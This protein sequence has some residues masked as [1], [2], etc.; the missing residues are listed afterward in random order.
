MTTK[1]DNCF[2]GGVQVQY[3][4][5]IKSP[6]VIVGESP[7]VMEVSEGKPFVG[8]SGQ[9]LE[10]A[11]APYMSLFVTPP[12]ITNAFGCMPRQKDPNKVT[13][14]TMRCNARLLG[15]LKAHPRKVILALGN[16]ALWS[17]TGDYNKKITQVRGQVFASALASDGIVS[18]VHPAFLLRGG[19]NIQQFKRDIQHAVE[20]YAKSAG[21][22]FA[23]SPS[24]SPTGM[25][26]LGAFKPSPY[27]VIQDV[28]QAALLVKKLK[29]AE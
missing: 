27:K 23:V 13:Q 24:A 12:L 2:F 29:S 26:I 9:L 3:K 20:L 25:A 1:C 5:D 10:Q 16:A 28:H 8:P 21:K 4:G 15:E 6:F 14:A 19:G 11:L 18:A 22:K 7:G 17:T